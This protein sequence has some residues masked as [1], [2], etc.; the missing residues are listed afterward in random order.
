MK[1]AAV[2]YL[3][4]IYI[5]AMCKPILPLVNDMLAHT[6]YEAEHIATVHQQYGKNHLHNDLKEAS[7]E[8]SNNN[9]AIVKASEPVS[10]HIF[11]EGSTLSRPFLMIEHSFFY[12][13]KTLLTPEEDI[14]TPPPQA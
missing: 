2:Y 7:K 5:M 3:F 4:L 8:N 6:F 9:T 14:I 1:Q 13:P 11:Y 10:V 12:L